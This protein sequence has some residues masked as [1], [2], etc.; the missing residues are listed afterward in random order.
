MQAKRVVIPLLLGALIFAGIVWRLAPKNIDDNELILIRT[1]YVSE[2][3]QA[4]EFICAN[5]Q[6]VGSITD[7]MP[8]V[9]GGFRNA[10]YQK[11]LRKVG[12]SRIEYRKSEI[13]FEYSHTS[14]IEK[15][16][17]CLTAASQTYGV[18]IT[19]PLDRFDDYKVVG[20][21][22]K[23]YEP[24]YFREIGERWAIYAFYN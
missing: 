16:L 12:A 22:G 15:G 18:T 11:M 20:S 14:C 10:T 17:R 2:L 9:D 7:R 4:V 23:S 24:Y 21:G 8:A 5:P 3:D 19:K 6:F 1:R 13:W